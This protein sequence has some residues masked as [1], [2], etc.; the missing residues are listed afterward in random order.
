MAR[1]NYQRGREFEYRT[2]KRMTEMGAAYIMRAA[3]SKGAADLIAL[4]PL[5]MDCVYDGQVWLVQC[6]MDGRLPKKEREELLRLS[7]LTGAR[8]VMSHKNKRGRL[9][10]KDIATNNAILQIVD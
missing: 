9:I 2:R 8:A 10:F 6:K 4:W 1:T 3:S 5:T 7:S